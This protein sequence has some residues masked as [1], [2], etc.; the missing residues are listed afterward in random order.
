MSD[1]GSTTHNVIEPII[2]RTYGDNGMS[3]ALVVH[4]AAKINDGDY[5]SRGREHMIMHICWDWFSGGTTAEAVAGEIEAQLVANADDG[6]PVGDLDRAANVMSAW[7]LEHVEGE[8]HQT[9][10]E[11]HPTTWREAAEVT[12]R[13]A[14]GEQ[15]ARPFT[16]TPGLPR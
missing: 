8:T 15:D 11:L 6:E 2:L 10:C 7:L 13:A 12:I 5:D 3:R 16:T 14:R 4:L 1:V 9:L